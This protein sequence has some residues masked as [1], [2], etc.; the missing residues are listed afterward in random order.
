MIPAKEIRTGWSVICHPAAYN[1]SYKFFVSDPDQVVECDSFIASCRPGMILFD[2]GANFGLFSLAALHYGAP[3]AKA[4][5][6]DPSPT[7]IR[8]MRIQSRLNDTGED[9]KIIQAAG[10]DKPGSLDLVSAGPVADGYFMPPRDHHGRE[11][12]RVR[13]VTIDSLIEET[14]LVPTHVKIDVEGHEEAV[15]RGGAGFLTTHNVDL[16]LELHN[17]TIRELGGTP[18]TIVALLRRFGYGTFKIGCLAVND[19]TIMAKE[20][21]RFIASR[22]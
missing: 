16:F 11:L 15:L 7:S 9:I 20:V 13:A 1:M 8:I 12:T 4:V 18:E 6:V 17:Q 2:I 14:K 22:Y 5:A 3:G 21:T 10:S 19:A